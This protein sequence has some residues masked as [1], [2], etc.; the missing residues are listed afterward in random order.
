MTINNVT[1]KMKDKTLSAATATSKSNHNSQLMVWSL[2]NW[3]QG[4]SISLELIL[5]DSMAVMAA[6]PAEQI[7]AKTPTKA[8]K[9]NLCADK[10]IP[11]S[12]VQFEIEIHFFFYPE[13][14]RLE[15]VQQKQM[16]PVRQLTAPLA[17]ATPL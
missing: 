12:F 10:E 14:D 5:D 2:S 11:W 6:D 4:W 16:K 1:D 17:M 9:Q 3:A 15:E 7:A 8:L 13:E